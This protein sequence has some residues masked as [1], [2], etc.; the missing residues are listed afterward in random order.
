M[1]KIKPIN[2]F[3]LIDLG[4]NKIVFV[5]YKKKE[6][7]LE[8]I[9]WNHIKTLGL[10]GG[11]IISIKQASESIKKIFA[12][13]KLKQEKKSVIVSISDPALTLKKTYFD[14]D[15]GHKKVKGI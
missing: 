7:N 3:I 1:L 4:T 9:N 6:N 2:H 13:C 15:I 10:T 8:L 5:E 14:V 12:N 11:K